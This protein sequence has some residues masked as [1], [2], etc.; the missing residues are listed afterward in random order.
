MAEAPHTRDMIPCSNFDALMAI[1]METGVR[2]E[3]WGGFAHRMEGD[4]PPSNS[5]QATLIAGSVMLSLRDRLERRYIICTNARVPMGG[6]DFHYADALLA[7]RLDDFDESGCCAPLLIASVQS[8]EDSH[9][10]RRPRPA[11]CVLLPSLLY[12]LTLFEDRMEVVL[13]CRQNNFS[14]VT[15]D[16]N[17]TLVLSD[18]KTSIPV[19]EFYAQVDL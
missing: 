9:V 6:D 8:P 7:Q 19:R 17:A 4:M 16:G 13:R 11:D 5:A 2:H 12:H 15:H 18:L 14:P 3:M 10:F 1:E